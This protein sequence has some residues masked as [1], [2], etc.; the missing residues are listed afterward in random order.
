MNRWISTRPAPPPQR[1][2]SREEILKAHLDSLPLDELRRVRPDNYWLHFGYEAWKRRQSGKANFNPNQ[3]RV[4]AGSPDGG[5]WTDAG[6]R[7]SNSP[8][9]SDSMDF[10]AAR[11]RGPRDRLPP[12]PHMFGPGEGGVPSYRPGQVTIVNNAQ[13]GFSTIDETTEK[14]RNALEKVVNSRGEG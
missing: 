7:H 10:S 5:Q 1:W 4:P 3:P 13:T 6:G 14:L 2:Q 12:L 11:R 8:S 9:R